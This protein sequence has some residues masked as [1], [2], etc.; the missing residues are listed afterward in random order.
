[1][2]EDELRRSLRSLSDGELP[3]D[4]VHRVVSELPDAPSQSARRW[5]VAAPALAAVIGTLLVGLLVARPALP[6]ADESASPTPVSP[7]PSSPRPSNTIAEEPSEQVILSLEITPGGATGG[8]DGRENEV[9]FRLVEGRAVYRDY[10]FGVSRSAERTAYLTPEQVAGLVEY[11]IGPG[12]MRHA[13]ERYERNSLGPSGST[14]ITLVSDEL[15]KQVTYGLAPGN[16]VE[17]PDPALGGLPD[18]VLRLSTFSQSVAAGDASGGLTVSQD[19]AAR[20]IALGDGRLQSVAASSY[21]VDR[22]MPAPGR[23]DHAFVDIRF[24]EPDV[25]VAGVDVCDIGGAVGEPT[26][27]MWLVDLGA[28]EVAAV[29]PVW[30]DVH[31]LGA[32]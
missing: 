2:N 16:L 11:A 13:A 25:L 22:V 8:I 17:D 9:V 20:A 30:G 32:R 5:H 23:P 1:M 31:C 3:P 12:G 6:G 24:T 19:Q 14:I 28:R 29:S 15:T 18:L 27:L 4:F 26:G 7:A 10:V 21:F